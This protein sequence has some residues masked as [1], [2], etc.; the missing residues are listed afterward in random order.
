MPVLAAVTLVRACLVVPA[1]GQFRRQPSRR[2]NWWRSDR[3]RSDR[4]GRNWRSH[5]RRNRR[6]IGRRNWWQIGRSD[7]WDTGHARKRRKR[8]VGQP[9][10]RRQCWISW[11]GRRRR[12]RRRWWRRR[13]RRI[14]GRRRRQIRWVLWRLRILGGLRILWRVFRRVGWIFG[15]RLVVFLVLVLRAEI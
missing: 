12:W 14:D 4:R 3:W 5:R 15:R 9:R 8:R 6:Q 1:L 7:W 2:L 10:D 11:R 13:R